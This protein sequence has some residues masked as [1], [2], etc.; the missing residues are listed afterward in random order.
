MLSSSIGGLGFR[1]QGLGL[2]VQHLEMPLS[3]LGGIKSVLCHFFSLILNNLASPLTPLALTD[4]PLAPPPTPLPSSL[5]RSK[6][7]KLSRATTPL[8]S[9]ALT[10]PLNFSRRLLW[11]VVCGLLFVVCGL[12]GVGFGFGDWGLES[13]SHKQK[14]EGKVR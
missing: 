12:G 2:R 1:V 5:G 4:P 8:S 13:R 11:F 10:L 3:S 9:A 6:L 14:V 7:F